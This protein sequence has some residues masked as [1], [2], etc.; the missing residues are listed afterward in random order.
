MKREK[1][2][3]RCH[4]KWE[5][6]DKMYDDKCMTFEYTADKNIKIYGN[7]SHISEAF[8]RACWATKAKGLKLFIA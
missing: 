3:A 7:Y 5:R 1:Y 6:V 2:L 4:K 8:V